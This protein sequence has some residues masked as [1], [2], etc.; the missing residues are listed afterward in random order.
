MMLMQRQAIA[1][2][3]LAVFA[4]VGGCSGNDGVASGTMGTTEGESTTLVQTTSVGEIPTTG[5]P[6]TGGQ[7]TGTDS[8][9]V[10]TTTGASTTD[11]TTTDDTTT[12]G[13]TTT[14]DT[15]TDDTTTGDP[16]MPECGNGVVEDGEDCDD[17]NA[18][19]TD[20]CVEGC[21]AATC[22][23]GF[24][25]ADVEGC[26]DGNDIDDDLCTNMCALPSCGD[27]IVQDGEACDDGN[28]DDTDACLSTCVVAS[29]GDGV[30]HA[31]VEACDDMG[32]SPQCNADCSVASCGDGIVNASA[33]EACD[34][35]GESA[36]CNADCSVAMCG[37]AI[38]NQAAGEACDDGNDITTDACIACVAAVCGDGFVHAGVEDCD[39]GN[40]INDDACAN[41]C[42]VNP[43]VCRNGSVE[44]TVAPSGL[45]KVC[46]DP[47]NQTCEQDQAQLCPLNWHLCSTKELNNRNAGWNYAVGGGKVVVGTIHCRSG[48]N[49]AGHLSLGPYDGYTNLGN[50]AIL[51]CGYGSSRPDTC[52]S[53][54]GCNEQF[55]EAL[56]CAPSPLCG[57][58]VVD[59]PE[60]ECDDGND[61]E[62]DACLNNCSWRQPTAHG[63]NGI[64]C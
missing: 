13:D 40:D 21:K 43:A 47:T 62:N 16:P 25:H 48:N 15:T 28:A 35:S 38:V 36:M 4:G 63:L 9:V 52:P 19:N 42:T 6:T 3:S 12:T 29:C 1:W 58:G 46:D 34:D 23:D 37:D 20:A 10:P 51:N 14:D 24:V 44:M 2:L 18:D 61:L 17:G 26:D 5:G 32:E 41:D 31:G 27:G 39:D 30:V 56:C 22:G 49:T 55:V 57:N 53:N 54:F 50:D 64:G 8:S 33:G 11:D 45:A 59:G 60:E 7:T